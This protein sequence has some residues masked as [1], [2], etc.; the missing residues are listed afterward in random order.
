MQGPE[1]R[2]QNKNPDSSILSEQTLESST[3]LAGGERL[4]GLSS[5]LGPPKQVQ[6]QWPAHLPAPAPMSDDTRTLPSLVLLAHGAPEHT[7]VENWKHILIA[8]T[9]LQIKASGGG[10]QGTGSGELVPGPLIKTSYF[11]WR[12]QPHISETIKINNKQKCLSP[13]PIRRTPAYLFSSSQLTACLDSGY[14]QPRP[15]R[16]QDSSPML[17][18][19]PPAT[20]NA[21]LSSSTRPPAAQRSR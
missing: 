16:M 10:R 12:L 11:T 19:L 15:T 18:L 8:D 4:L 9:T 3:V 6:R 21:F 7:L 1:F 14:L 5:V 2:K 20:H 17:H 13:V